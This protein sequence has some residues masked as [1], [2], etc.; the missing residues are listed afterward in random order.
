MNKENKEILSINELRYKLLQMRFAKAK[1]K[2]FFSSAYKKT[3]K[4]LARSLTVLKN[5]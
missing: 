2:K 4:Q 5:K 1:K 3:R